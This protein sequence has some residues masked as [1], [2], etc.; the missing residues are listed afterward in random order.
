MKSQKPTKI[1]KQT[2][3]IIITIMDD[4]LHDYDVK[5]AFRGRL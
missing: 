3:K 1:N 5:D 4:S 2:I